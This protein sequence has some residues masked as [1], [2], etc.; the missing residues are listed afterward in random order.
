L[1]FVS[2]A[3]IS[4]KKHRTARGDNEEEHRQ[5]R[6]ERRAS[7]QTLRDETSLRWGVQRQSPQLACLILR[8]RSAFSPKAAFQIA[9]NL[10]EKFDLASQ[11]FCAIEALSPG[12][13]E[14]RN[15]LT[16]GQMGI[17]TLQSAILKVLPARTEVCISTN[18]VLSCPNVYNPTS[19]RRT[20]VSHS[21]ARPV[22]SGLA[23]RSRYQTSRSRRGYFWSRSS[24]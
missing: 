18:D 9:R 11:N 17:S 15:G 4:T 19:V 23:L 2:H 1:A 3:T 20:T 12:A 22:L 24:W 14:T 16:E 10:A 13:V 7:Y 6:L 21:L 5:H 8:E